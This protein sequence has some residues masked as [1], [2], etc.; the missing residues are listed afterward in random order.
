MVTNVLI[1]N[2]HRILIYSLYSLTCFV[3]TV[4][5]Y[6]L[7]FQSAMVTSILLIALIVAPVSAASSPQLPISVV[8]G[9]GAKWWQ[10][11]FSF[12]SDDSPLT[13]LRGDRC[14][15][16][17]QG[18]VFFL[19]GIAG[20]SASTGE[21]VERTC[22]VAIS[23]KQAILIPILNAACLLTTPCANPNE[24]VDNMKDLQSE[25]SALVNGVRETRATIQKEGEGVTQLD[26]SNSRVQTASFKVNVA[27]DNPFDAPEIG[28]PTPAGEFR[29]TADGYWVLLK[30]LSPGTYTIHV[31]GFVPQ[32]PPAAD[33]VIDVTYHIT[34]E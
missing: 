5:P 1:Y 2:M 15:K 10:W 7:V 21:P 31:Q 11:A 16:G 6:S 22:N 9:L 29:A 20:P 25:L 8:K 19:A 26:T 34:V 12:S 33:F 24:S 3:M 17:D 14:D 4:R 18:K 27:E 32:P 30:P 13:D 28:F 23:Q